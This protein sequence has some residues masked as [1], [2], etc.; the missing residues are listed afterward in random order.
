MN[1]VIFKTPITSLK[2]ISGA[3]AKLFAKLD[4]FSVYDLLQFF[5][6]MYRDRGK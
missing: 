2:G 3:R 5:P 1:D 4:V 6:R